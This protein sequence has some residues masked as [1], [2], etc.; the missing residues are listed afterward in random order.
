MKKFIKMNSSDNHLSL[1]N[2][3]RTIKEI[4]NNKVFASQTE[5][6]CT[7]FNI[8]DISDS[9][10]NNYCIGYRSIGSDYKDIYYNFKK[11][12]QNDDFILIDITLNIIS[13]LDGNIYTNDN[14]IET[15]KL[16]NSNS[17]FQKL[18]NSLYN[19]AKNDNSIKNDFTIN[20]KKLIDNN[21]YYHSF[22]KLLFFIILEKK[23]PIYI[24]NLVKNAIESILSKT[25]VSLIDLENFLNTEFMDGINYFYSIKKMAK[26]NNPYAN[27]ELAMMEYK[28]EISGK[29]RYNKC[30]EYLEKTANSNHPRAN[31]MIAS[32]IYNKKIGNLEQEDLKKAWYHLNIAIEAGSIAAINTMGL[33]YLKGYV[34]NQKANINKAIELFTKAS[35]H[36]Y[37]YAY[38][39][40]GKIYENKKDLKKA[41][42]YYINSALLEES[43]ACNKIGNYYRLGIG[44]EKDLKKAFEYYIKASNSPINTMNKWCKYNLAKYFYLNGSYEAN[45]EKDINKAISLFESISS[46]I[47]EACIELIYIYSDLYLKENN[48]LYKINID[49]YASLCSKFPNYNDQIKKDI[50]NKL[51][52]IKKDNINTNIILKEN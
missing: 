31:F 50:E 2:L 26:D 25:N 52:Q 42:E 3:C 19:I 33:A 39:N 32:L 9:T 43:W 8:D 47:M 34:P 22:S 20:L 28:G 1:G 21:D 7:I 27:F 16:I 24:D 4:S 37:A 38:N 48:E 10:V 6:F 13:I 5:I 35:E 11:K 44:C 36:N 12:M 51:K 40:L 18:I 46:Y 23:Q 29:P 49:K 45:I 30:Y 17:N 14:N 15:L 41:F